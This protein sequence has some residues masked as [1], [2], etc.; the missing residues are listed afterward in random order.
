MDGTTIWNI[1]AEGGYFVADDLAVKLGLG[2][3][4]NSNSPGFFSYKGGAKY[5]I[6]GVVPVQVDLNGISSK[7]FDNY[8]PLFLGI[9]GGY[10]WFVADNIAVEPGLRYDFGLNDDAEASEGVAFNIGFSLYF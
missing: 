4:D 9:Q 8:N 6:K 7:I 3:G 2:Y 1:G 10:A 5:Y